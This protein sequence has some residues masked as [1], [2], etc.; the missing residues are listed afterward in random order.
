MFSIKQGN[1]QTYYSTC[2]IHELKS[3]NGEYYLI[4]KPFDNIGDTPLGKTTVYSS[5]NRVLYTIPKYFEITKDRKNLFLSNDG[6]HIAYVSNYEI[7]SRDFTIHSTELFLEGESFKK[8]SL[9]DLIDCNSDNEDC[10]LFFNEVIDSVYW[11]NGEKKLNINASATE[12]EKFAAVNPV[13]C[14][15]D[16]VFIFTKNK[17]L[18]KIDLKTGE[19]TKNE[20]TDFNIAHLE[21]QTDFCIKTTS[22]KRPN[23]YGLPKLQN[24]KQI[25]ESL[26]DYL[27]M[28]IFPE[29]S[30][31]ANRFKKYTLKLD[32]VIDTSGYTYI[33]TVENYD[34]L[35]IEKINDFFKN[36]L[37]D[38]SHIPEFVDKWQ[39]SG[40]IKLMNKNRR[41]AKKE[42]QIELQQERIAYQKR[43]VADSINGLY[44]P[45]NI[46]ECFI[47]LDK[48]LK[49]KDIETIKALNSRDETILYHH[50]FGTWIRNNWGLWGGSRL[51]Q[52]LI[53]KGLRHPDDM[54]AKILEFY[55]DWLNNQNEAWKQF[56][57]K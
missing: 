55:Y 17:T 33:E 50:G 11:D 38:V 1:A 46:E 40:W 57:M 56:D 48:L 54:S 16:T 14:K 26:A 13:L 5:D 21:Q 22:F 9:K 31:R 36:E 4:T 53:K 28:V 15:N 49:P 37:V 42:R 19:L 35:D 30:R 47:E 2:E 32:I 24:G 52:Y 3:Q 20:F 39:F 44:I 45:K 10:F 51:Q 23:I 12:K 43:L 18:L 8:Y 6:M 34:S 7:I 29:D 41:V 27:D 25:D